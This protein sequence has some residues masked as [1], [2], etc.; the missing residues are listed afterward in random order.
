MAL[1]PTNQTVLASDGESWREMRLPAPDEEVM[2]GVPW[3]HFDAVLTPAFWASQ[4]WI[5]S[6]GGQLE[7]Y[8]L[9]ATLREEV[10]AC[11]L[12]GYGMPAE[13]GLAAFERLRRYG[14]LDAGSSAVAIEAALREPLQ[15][16]ARTL[17]YRFARQKAAYLA[18]ALKHLDAVV[19]EGARG[20][21]LRD[22]LATLRGVGP[23]T[24]SWI[25]RNWC[26]AD[27]VAI[28]DVH[29]CRACEAAGVFVRGS[30]PSNKYYELEARFLSFATALSVRPSVLDNLIWQTMRRLPGPIVHGGLNAL[31]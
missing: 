18:E 3:G 19:P 26:D 24:A 16:G 14:L 23:K 2:P 10:A 22:R 5:H 31:D 13:L 27:D 1:T 28:L 15:V 25:T 4:V 7:Q 6:P 29:V 11:M 8:R 9:G 17:R 20:R 21:G 12:G 30:S